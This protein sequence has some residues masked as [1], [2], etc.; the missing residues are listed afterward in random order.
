MV[1]AVLA[2]VYAMNTVDTAAT[3]STA[4]KGVVKTVAAVGVAVRVVVVLVELEPT[5]GLRVKKGVVGD[6]VGVG[7][8][9]SA[10]SWSQ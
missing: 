6:G 8:G 3:T 1:A 7:V 5:V 9:S 2:W 10:T 4:I